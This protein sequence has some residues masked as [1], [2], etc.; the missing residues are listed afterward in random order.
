[1]RWWELPDRSRRR[2][3]DRSAHFRTSALTCADVRAHFPKTTTQKP[4]LQNPPPATTV[5]A[6]THLGWLLNRGPP[7]PRFRKKPQ[8]FVL[9][10]TRPWTLNA[11]RCQGQAPGPLN[12][13]RC[14]GHP[15]P[16]NGRPTFGV[17]LRPPFC[18]RLRRAFAAL[19]YM[20]RGA[21]VPHLGYIAR[22]ILRRTVLLMVWRPDA[23]ELCFPTDKKPSVGPLAQVQKTSPGTPWTRRAASQLVP[24]TGQK[25]TCEPLNEPLATRPGASPGPQQ[26]PRR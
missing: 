17:V 19:R 6:C 1:L 21:G 25:A 10:G 3:S 23:S 9:P 4:Q 7:W 5:K 20:Q 26:P 11:E 2:R 24:L 8:H 14:Q 13:E 18:T 16:K 15:G 22:L 12:A